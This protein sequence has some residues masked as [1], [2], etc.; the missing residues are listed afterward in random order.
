M[1]QLA[2]IVPF[3]LF[4][5]F[6]LL[7]IYKKKKP[8]LVLAAVC[9]LGFLFAAYLNNRLVYQAYDK[10]K[11]NLKEM[12]ARSDEDPNALNAEYRQQVTDFALKV[13]AE[14]KERLAQ[15]DWNRENTDVISG[16]NGRMGEKVLHEIVLSFIAQTYDFEA[17]D[18]TAAF[19]GVQEDPGAFVGEYLQIYGKYVGRAA[20]E[21]EDIVSVFLP[22]DGFT[23]IEEHIFLNDDETVQV[24]RLMYLPGET[25]DAYLEDESNRGSTAFPMEG[26]FIG[27]YQAEDALYYVLVFNLA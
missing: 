25:A 23:L 7:Y 2:Y 26:C 9:A 8:F 12:Q 21:E 5:V 24:M 11:D 3:I 6:A 18:T 15:M 16:G 14:E 13:G 10:Y 4:F 22:I 17:F 1:T 27:T 19:S 20:C